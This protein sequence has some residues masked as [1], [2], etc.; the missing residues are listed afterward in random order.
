MGRRG[1][2]PGLWALRVPLPRRRLHP[3]VLTLAGSSRA[4]NASRAPSPPLPRPKVRA[5]KLREVRAGHD[6]TWVAHPDLVKVRPN[7]GRSNGGAVKRGAVKRGAVK[8]GAVKRGGGQTGG[9][10]TE[11]GQTE[12]GQTEGGQTGRRR[13]TQERARRSIPCSRARQRGPAFPWV[14]LNAAIS[15]PPAPHPPPPHPPPPTPHPPPPTPH[16][17]P[18]VALE[19]FNE[20][21]P[22]ANQLFARREDVAVAAEDLL[23]TK[24]LP[25]GFG[26]ADVRLNMNIALSERRGGWGLG[27][28]GARWVQA[29]LACSRRGKRQ[30]TMPPPAKPPCP[31]HLPPKGYMESWLRGVGCVPIH[32][33]M[34][35]AATAEISRSQLW[36]WARHGA[37]TREGA[38]VTGEWAARLLRE[39]TDKFR[40]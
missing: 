38:R 5:D 23:S 16:P 12:G 14:A 7:G 28:G 13:S 21:M 8:R 9:G 2:R 37:A 4:P 35:D 40:E 26:E 32:N 34:E 25:R 27:D 31:P 18:Q 3:R 19:V 22:L 29:G 20:H 10:Q 39:E 17:P 1:G 30:A 15:W 24:G 33:L 11:G 36:Q 6:G